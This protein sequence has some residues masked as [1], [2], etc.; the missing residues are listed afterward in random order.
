MPQQLGLVPKE[1]S[2]SLD[3]LLS[4]TL[5]VPLVDAQADCSPGW[6]GLAKCLLAAAGCFW[7]LFERC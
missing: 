7:D 6:I 4:L 2:S 5:L 1:T 3:E